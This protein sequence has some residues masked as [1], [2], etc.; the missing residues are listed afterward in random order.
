[1]GYWYVDDLKDGWCRVYYS[2][3]SQL[4]RFVPGF[5]GAR[6]I[7]MAARRSTSWVAARCNQLPGYAVGGRA[8]PPWLPT[9]KQATLLLLLWYWSKRRAAYRELERVLTSI[10]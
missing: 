7:N 4:P 3:D 2:G 8:S 6:L 5:I 10:G 9:R 1:M